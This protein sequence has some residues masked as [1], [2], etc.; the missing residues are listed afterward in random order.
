MNKFVY[1]LGFI[2]FTINAYSQNNLEVAGEMR[3]L[4]MNT[5]N[6]ANAIVVRL[7]DGTLAYRDASTLPGSEIQ[8]LSISNDTIYLSSGGF[9]VILDSDKS[10]TNELQTISRSGLD[11]TLSNNGGTVRDSVNVYTAGDQISITNNVIQYTGNAVPNVW[12]LGQ[13]TLGGIVFYIYK[14]DQG[15]DHGLIVSKNED[16]LKWR[17]STAITGANS[18]WDGV[19]N[20]ALMTNSPAKNWVTSNFST[21]WYLPSIDEIGLLWQNRLHTNRALEDGGHTALLSLGYWSS[22][23]Q[24]N[25]SFRALRLNFVSGG[26]TRS[27]KTD[28]NGVRAIRAF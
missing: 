28:A 2:C 7:A 23:E 6:S 12:Y 9:V 24:F 18:G 11:I 19:S 20:T 22:T 25:S 4:Q 10:V 1:V 15:I 3:V 27:Q 16:V 14:D 17:N 26:V 8:V 21:E 5:D 13:D